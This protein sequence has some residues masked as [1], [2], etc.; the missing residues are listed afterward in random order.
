MGNDIS[1]NDTNIKKEI[2]NKTNNNNNGNNNN[3]DVDID[4][5]KGYKSTSI[6]PEE[7]CNAPTDMLFWL[8][9]H[10]HH[11]HH[12]YRYYLSLFLL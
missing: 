12:Y 4:H 2:A 3:N 6:I 11:H 7:V 8:G 5:S 1:Y 10:H 9:N